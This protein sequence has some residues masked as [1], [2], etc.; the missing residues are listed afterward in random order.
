MTQNSQERIYQKID[1]H[2]FASSFRE[3]DIAENIVRDYLESEGWTVSVIP[4]PKEKERGDFHIFHPAY[5][6]NH[7][8]DI[9]VKCDKRA[10]ETY[11]F[12]LET[13]VNYYDKEGVSPG[14]AEYTVAKEIYYYFPKAGTIWV[15]P[16]ESIKSNLSD[17]EKKYPKRKAQNKK[18][19]GIGVLVPAIE[20]LR[21]RT[22]RIELR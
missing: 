8:Y 4:Q 11:K 1:I 18:W 10:E 17:W 6:S 3:G 9:E 12:F 5:C 21:I 7:G 22:K 2:D 13:G 15:I 19:H 20:M 16:S 14:W